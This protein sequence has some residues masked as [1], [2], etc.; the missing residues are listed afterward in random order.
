MLEQAVDHRGAVEARGDREPPRH[1][2]GLEPAHLLHPA[3][4]QLQLCPASRKRIEAALDTPR[5]EASQ[6][7]VSVIARRSRI[8]G[9]VGSNRPAQR[10]GSG[11]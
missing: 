4:V 1:G 3:D 9:Q 7:R 10:I 11:L 5:Q 6:V 2:G 8:A